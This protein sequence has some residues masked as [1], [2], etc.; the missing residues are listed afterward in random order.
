[1]SIINILLLAFYTATI[2]QVFY[3]IFIFTKLIFYKE[4]CTPKTEKGVS[5]VICARNEYH[6]LKNNLDRFLSQN[7]RSYEIIVVDDCSTDETPSLLLQYRDTHSTFAFV[8]ITNKLELG[9]KVALTAGIKAARFDTILLSDADCV[10]NSDDWITTMV[11][12]L[13]SS[14]KIVLGYGAYKYADSFLNRFIRFETVLTAIQY[15]S[16]ALHGKPYMGVGR[17]LMYSKNLFLEN[18]GFASHQHLPSGDD[19]L[20]INEVATT[21]NTAICMHPSGFTYSEPAQTLRNFYRQKNRHYAVSTSYDIISQLFL[22]LFALSYFIH[23][24]GGIL[25]MLLGVTTQKLMLTLAA[26]LIITWWIFAHLVRKFK[27]KGL[28][29]WFPILELLLPI[30]YMVFTPASMFKIKKW[31]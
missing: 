9:K 12:N 19:D 6:N 17:N 24:S 10:P 15:M 20:F 27:E 3:W 5:V 7:Y 14:K 30:Y 18:D 26:R 13:D 28:V 4:K 21:T 22:G 1:M 8:N 2:I 23:F 31:K 11:A 16:Y 29:L 25:L